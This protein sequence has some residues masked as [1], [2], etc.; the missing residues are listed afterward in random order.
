MNHPES[1]LLLQLAARQMGAI[2]ELQARCR[3]LTGAVVA[4]AKQQGLPADRLDTEIRRIT[5]EDFQRRLEELEKANPE[6]AAH[7][8]HRAPEDL[9]NE[10]IL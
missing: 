2:L 1:K 3:A 4:L 10:P 8:D 5:I 9:I 6:L 7:V